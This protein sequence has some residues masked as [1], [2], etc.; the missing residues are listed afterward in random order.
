MTVFFPAHHPACCV[1]ATF[2]GAAHTVSTR[3]ECVTMAFC[4]PRL[5]QVARPS[6]VRL[7]FVPCRLRLRRRQ[8]GLGRQ[9]DDLVTIKHRL[10]LLITA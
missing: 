2:A 1:F 3:V 5:H 7:S 9:H 10:H 8:R 4:L 6:L